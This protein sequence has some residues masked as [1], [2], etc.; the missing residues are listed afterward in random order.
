MVVAIGNNIHASII[1]TINLVE[2][3]VPEII[4]RVDNADYIPVMNKLGA[5]RVI[6]PEESSA[7]SFAHQIVSVN[8]A[9]Y[10]D[11]QG[12]FAIV[13]IQVH[14][15][16]KP[17]SLIELDSRNKYGVNVVGII[18]NGKFFIPKGTDIVEEG[19]ELMVIGA[20]ENLNRFSLSLEK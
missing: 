3:K 2:L 15:G 11:I 20:H 14:K 8:F 12:D 4:V 5:S 7:V 18:H 10:Y 9:D 16:Y 13:K 19:D 17:K 1:T 6:V